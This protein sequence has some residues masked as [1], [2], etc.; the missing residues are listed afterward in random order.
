MGVVSDIIGLVFAV[1]VA[2]LCWKAVRP[3]RRNRNKIDG[4]MYDDIE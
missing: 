2:F 1:F 4:S 3:S